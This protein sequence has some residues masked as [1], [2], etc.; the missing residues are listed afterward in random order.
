MKDNIT[1]NT[2]LKNAVL[3]VPSPLASL[4]ASRYVSCSRTQA[5]LPVCFSL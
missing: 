4:L 5:N 1:S 3:T 2:P